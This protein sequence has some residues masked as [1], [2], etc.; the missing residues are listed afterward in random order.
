[1]RRWR[2]TVQILKTSIEDDQI[3]R[4]QS[5]HNYDEH[6]RDNQS[7]DSIHN[8]HDVHQLVIVWLQATH[9]TTTARHIFCN[10]GSEQRINV[11]RKSD[12]RQDPNNDFGS[13][14]SAHKRTLKWVLDSNQPLESVGDREPDAEAG[15][16]GTAVDHG[17]AEAQ[18]VK[19]VDPNLVQPGDH[20][21]EKVSKVC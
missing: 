7:Y 14:D 20:R 9:F 11:N 1:M 2:L 18:P 5:V 6:Q 3:L 16:D 12:N 4:N 17:L 15:E 8:V 10:P 13:M 19:E 21:S